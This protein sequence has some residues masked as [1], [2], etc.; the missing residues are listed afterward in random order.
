[1]LALVFSK[2]QLT[3]NYKAYEAAL[4]GLNSI[5]GYAVKANFNKSIMQ[6]LCGLGSGAVVVSGHELALAIK[7]GFNPERCVFNGNGKLREEL[8]YGVQM[9]SLVNIDSEFDFE[10]IL[11]AAKV[12]R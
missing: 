6:H 4:D 1:M 9:G 11:D 7:F 2:A 8:A 5:I 10:N 3:A 12:R